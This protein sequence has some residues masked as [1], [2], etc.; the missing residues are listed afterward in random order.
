MSPSSFDGTA[1]VYMVSSDGVLVESDVKSE[2]GI[3]PVI[4]IKEDMPVSYG[5][6][7]INEPYMLN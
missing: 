1:K 2:I 7:L 4:S 3:R 5:S 6:G